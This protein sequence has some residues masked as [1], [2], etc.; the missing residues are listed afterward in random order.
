MWQIREEE[1]YYITANVTY[2]GADASAGPCCQNSIFTKTRV[3][4]EAVRLQEE[5]KDRKGIR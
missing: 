4:T 2:I 3:Q 1:A 5:R